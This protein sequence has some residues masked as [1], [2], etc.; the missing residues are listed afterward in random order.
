MRER[1]LLHVSEPTSRPAGRHDFSP[2]AAEL[3]AR[4]IEHA[5]VKPMET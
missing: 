1:L 4:A 2:K 5:L 3:A